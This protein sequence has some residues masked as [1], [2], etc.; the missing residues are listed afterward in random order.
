M[1]L[2]CQVKDRRPGGRI[3]RGRKPKG[4]SH[5]LPISDELSGED[6]LAL[7]SPKGQDIEHQRGR[8]QW[9]VRKESPQVCPKT[10]EIVKW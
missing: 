5:S 3:K 9:D 4:C 8:C 7:Y 6:A 10:E 1:T 2:R